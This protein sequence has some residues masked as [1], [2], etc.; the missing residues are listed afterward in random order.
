M[1]NFAGKKFKNAFVVSSGP[2]TSSIDL[3]KKAEKWGA[4]AVSTKLTFVK[5][6]FKSELR[7]YS[8][9]G[10]ALHMCTDRRLSKDEGLQLVRKVKKET[11]LIVFANISSQGNKLEDWVKLA[12]GFEEAGADIIEA[13]FCCTNIGLAAYE[14]GEKTRDEFTSG[15]MVGRIPELVKEVTEVLKNTVRIPVV[16]KIAP[17]T[18]NLTE[19]AVACKEGGADGISVV[20]AGS[21]GLPSLDIY[22]QARPLIPLLKGVSFDCLTGPFNKFATYKVVAQLARS[23]KIPIIASGGIGNWRDAVEA[24]MWGATL[25]SATTSIMWNGFEI[26][27]KIN[28]GI[29]KFM[30]EQGYSSY[31]DFRGK[32][33]QY[34]TTPDKIKLIEGVAVVNEEKCN[35]CS[36]CLRPGHCTAIEISNGKAYINEDKCLGCSICTTICPQGALGMR[37]KKVRK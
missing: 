17:I 21:N 12:R 23:I 28:K 27:K 31:D 2:L 22:N 18:Q 3:I 35:G 11:S 6:P 8:I 20:G 15:V 19:V 24:M 16:P 1:I 36:I 5:V 30:K 7:T 34:L 37:E 10:F 25:V 32:A 4:S 9:P 13:N 29:K 14:L 26:I 33:L